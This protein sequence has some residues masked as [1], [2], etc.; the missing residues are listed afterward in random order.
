M[1]TS[2]GHGPTRRLYKLRE[3]G[4]VPTPFACQ[5][6]SNHHAKPVRD[7]LFFPS[8]PALSLH[9]WAERE[10]A[11]S[12]APRRLYDSSVMGVVRNSGVPRGGA[13]T[14]TPD[15]QSIPSPFSDLTLLS[16]FLVGISELVYS[17]DVWSPRFVEELLPCSQQVSL[18]YNLSY[19]CLGKFPNCKRQIRMRALETQL[20]FR[21]SEAVLLKC[22]GTSQN[23]TSSLFPKLKLAVEKNKPLLAVRYLEKAKTWIIDI[24]QEVDKMTQRYHKLNEDVATSTSDIIT[25]KRENEKKSV[26][27][28]EEIK[29]MRE[30]IENHRKQQKENTTELEEKTKSIEEK[31]QKLY[32]LIRNVTTMNKRFAIVAAC[33]PI[34]GPIIQA[35]YEL[36]TS[37]DENAKLKALE[38]EVD[39]LISEKTTLKQKAWD[40]Q[41]VILDYELK[42]SKLETDKG[43]V[44][45]SALLGDV[46][47]YLSQI[48]NV[49]IQLKA[50]W[51]KVYIIVTNIRD[52]TFVDEELID[53]P[54]LHEDFLKSIQTASELFVLFGRSGNVFGG[55]GPCDKAAQLFRVQSKEAYNFLEM[56][57][58]SLSEDVWKKEYEKV[59][60]RLKAIKVSGGG[61]N[62]NK[63][64][65]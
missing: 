15:A 47:R 49:L 56:D 22:T 1:Q 29:G 53:D 37:P 57:P 54:D 31:S 6:P 20:L 43:L 9:L 59:K 48:Q 38:L 7:I 18:L 62:Q 63:T 33:V 35:V 13:P 27:L 24:I 10:R 42:L 28:S 16:V 26:Q 23:L 61:H 36:N 51:E 34:I 40:I 65:Q 11:V 5:D 14:L 45:D 30:V 8:R 52:K 41:V 60:G 46:Q 3:N 25:E 19:L 44:P 2:P 39:R 32:D 64:I 58:A 17:K 21:S 4:K 12:T 55:G 50:F